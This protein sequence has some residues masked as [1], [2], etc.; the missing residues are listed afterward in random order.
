MFLMGPKPLAMWAAVPERCAA[1]AG[2]IK[3]KENGMEGETCLGGEKGP[4]EKPEHR[5]QLRV[6]WSW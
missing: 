2:R 4:K 3:L 6:L 5:Q 1:N